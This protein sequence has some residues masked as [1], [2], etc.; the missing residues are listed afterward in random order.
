MRKCCKC[1]NRDAT[2]SFVITNSKTSERHHI[3]NI[4]FLVLLAFLYRNDYV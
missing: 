3:C 4:C 2:C 1:K